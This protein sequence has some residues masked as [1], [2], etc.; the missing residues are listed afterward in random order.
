M[1]KDMLWNKFIVKFKLSKGQTKP[2]ARLA[3]HRFSQKMNK[4][5]CFVCCDEAKKQTKQIFCSF[6]G[7]IY[8]APICFWFHLTCRTQKNMQRFT[9]PVFMDKYWL[10]LHGQSKCVSCDAL[11]GIRRLTKKSQRLFNLNYGV[12]KITFTTKGINC[13]CSAHLLN[14]NTKLLQ[15]TNV[16]KL[17]KV[18]QYLLTL[19]CI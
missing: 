18:F 11:L 1:T 8:N 15:D 2:K 9:Y 7:R 14:Q 4:Q 3:R 17:V 19:Q 10:L 5:I 16:Y 13:N 12:D 6:F